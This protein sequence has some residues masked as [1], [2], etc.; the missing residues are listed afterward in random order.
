MIEENA[1]IGNFVEVKKSRVGRGSKAQH[2]TYLGDATVGQYVNVGA[3]TVTCNYDG[4]KKKTTV[5]E[6]RVFIGSGNMLVAPVRIG[7]GAYT[8]AG[9]TITEDV[10]PDSLAIAR[11]PQVTKPGWVKE[12]SQVKPRN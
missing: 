10:P 11:S 3:G 12:R 8:A 6:D 7:Q 1:R 5:I 2:L 9:S 4:V